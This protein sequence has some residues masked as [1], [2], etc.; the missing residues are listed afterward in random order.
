[1]D[2][3]RGAAR[4]LDEERLSRERVVLRI[5]ALALGFNVVQ[6]LVRT[7]DSVAG[8]WLLVVLLLAVQA[9]A[10]A[11]LRRPDRRRVRAAGGSAWRATPSSS[12]APWRTT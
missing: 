8:T 5:R 11:L 4:A 1:M 12:P 10:A 6:S 2:H 9:T 3:G 7:G